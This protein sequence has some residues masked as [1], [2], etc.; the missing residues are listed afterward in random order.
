MGHDMPFPNPELSRGGLGVESKDG[1][2]RRTG[3]ADGDDDG[4]DTAA[5]VDARAPV[6]IPANMEAA[7][8][9]MFDAHAFEKR[10]TNLAAVGVS[11]EDEV[12]GK[13]S[14][15]GDDARVV[16]EKNDGTA[17]GD[18]GEGS[19]EIRVV[20]EVVHAG[21]VEQRGAGADDG[22][23]VAQHLDAVAAEGAGDEIGADTE[24]VIAENGKDAA[25]GAKPAE[26]LAGRVSEIAG[27]GN[28]V[29]GEGDNVGLER[30]GEF[31]GG[32]Q[33]LRGKIQA[34]VNVGEMDDAKAVQLAAEPG[35]G[36]AEFVDFDAAGFPTAIVARTGG[37]EIEAELV[38][39]TALEAVE[40]AVEGAF[41]RLHEHRG[42]N[43]AGG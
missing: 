31:D 7:A 6:R 10:E 30:I 9:L 26:K 12:N 35:D 13:K 42:E 36:D 41:A 5:D 32:E 43:R 29:A 14:G 1:Y 11:G 21:D 24:I 3:P 17:A 8:R 38:E 25:A 22:M 39:V 18:A 2:L 28:E 4:A 37:S 27:V 23:A 40:P 20:P 15:G 16:G 19:G 34:V 33:G